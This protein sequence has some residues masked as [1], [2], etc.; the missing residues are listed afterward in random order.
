M[1]QSNKTAKGG[2]LV[3]SLLEPTNPIENYLFQTLG[4]ATCFPVF[5]FL[6]LR[7]SFRFIL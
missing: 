6:E 3:I 4:E 2:V 1:D 7:I 5:L